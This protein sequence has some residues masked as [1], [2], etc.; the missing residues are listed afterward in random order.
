MRTYDPLAAKPRRHFENCKICC[1]RFIEDSDPRAP[2]RLCSKHLPSA[3]MQI[4]NVPPSWWD[5]FWTDHPEIDPLKDE[6]SRKKAD[7]G[8]ENSPETP[9]A[10]VRRSQIRRGH[11][12]A[13]DADSRDRPQASE[14][15]GGTKSVADAERVRR[16]HPSLSGP[17]RDGPS[18]VVR[19]ETEMKASTLKTKRYVASADIA[20]T[21]Q[22]VLIDDVKI[23]TLKSL[24]DGTS[25]QKGVLYFAGDVVKPLALNSTNVDHLIA[26]FGDD[27]DDWVGKSVK[28]VV[29]TVDAFGQRVPGIRIAE[30][31]VPKRKKA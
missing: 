15:L 1:D 16:N 3:A 31:A 13:R 21:G 26:L 2:L 25:Q 23:E 7:A 11:L 17:I 6:T 8:K 10:F 20:P 24:K 4:K 27:T 19:G 9:N 22:T 29:E 30:Q 12:R 14:D 18:Q 5:E 28:L